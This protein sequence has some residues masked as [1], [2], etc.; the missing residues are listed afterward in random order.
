MHVAAA[1]TEKNPSE[2]MR[3]QVLMSMLEDEDDHQEVVEVA[4]YPVRLKHVFGRTPRLREFGAFLFT[5]D[6]HH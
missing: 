2:L 4:E 6:P 1:L 5:H 3:M